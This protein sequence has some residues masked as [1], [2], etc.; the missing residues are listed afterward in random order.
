VPTVRLPENYS[1]LITVPFV[2]YGIFRYLY[3]IHQHDEGESPEDILLSDKP[4]IAAV[5]L[6]LFVSGGVLLANKL[7]Q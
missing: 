4:L 7:L 5:L 6:W 2:A 3:L 1:M